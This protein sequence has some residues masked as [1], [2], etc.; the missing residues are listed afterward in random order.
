MT[1]RAK[2]SY[3]CELHRYD[4]QELLP[5]ER[6]LVS[7]AKKAS[8]TAYAPYSKFNVGAAAL[9]SDNT[10]VFGSNQENAAY[11]SGLCAE[12]VALFACGAQQSGKRVLS[13]AVYAPALKDA[14]A[15][16][17]P[18]GSCRQVMQETEHHQNA[19]LRI[20]LI[21]SNNHVYLAENAQTL[22]PFPFEF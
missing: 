16:P 7:K 4:L 11:P 21:T 5:A 3:L 13:L 22:L 15:V 18:C 20:L 10:V 17:M 1:Q 19:P 8:E 2:K 6:D 12:R 9:L 14:D